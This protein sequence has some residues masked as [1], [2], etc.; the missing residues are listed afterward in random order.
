MNDAAFL[1]ILL[2]LIAL[3]G[4][5]PLVLRRFGIPGVIALLITGMLV[6]PTGI[7]CDLVGHISRWLSFLGT[8]GQEAETA[9]ATSESFNTIINS[10][11]SLGLM[12]LM[13]L[14]GMEA[15]FKLINSV[16]KPVVT[17][18]VLTFLL[19]AAAGY[20]VYWHF[21]PED[22]AGKLLYASLFASH[23]VG[24]VFPV[25]RELKLSKSRFG[26]A[27]LISTV[28]T[29]I[30]SIVLLAVSVQLHRQSLHVSH[31][32]GQSTLSIFDH[33]NTTSLLGNSFVLVFLLLV[34]V[35]L[36][37]SVYAVRFVGNV[38]KK[39]FAPTEDMLITI[40]LMV[41][42]VTVVIG[43]LFG[44]NLVVGAF[45]AG[46]GLSQVVKEKDMVLFKRVESIG[47]GFLIP[48]LFVS[49]GM[50]TDFTAFGSAGN[51]MII[52]L[53]VSGLVISKIFSG[54]IA[55]RISGFSNSQGVA[56]GLM[57]VPQ[58]S[59]TLAAAAIGKDMGLLSEEFFNA[60]IILSIVTTLPIPSLVK[61]VISKSKA[62]FTEADGVS[63]PSVVKSDELL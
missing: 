36:V 42:L 17:L 32:V 39:Y 27:V 29:D 33:V 56:A 15:D 25:M 13:A 23:S 37:V 28:I 8:P 21:R 30:A 40:V 48:F 24:I 35:Y 61:L 31:M 54:Y 26:A 9:L 44:I 41:I 19:P 2:A 60:I 57:T 6:G 46:L 16:K 51:W 55:M 43:E 50:K 20:L 62:S 47:Y 53:T 14:A 10:L 1:I 12:L 5:I 22:L 45:I 4:M 34:V 38:L 59:A 49:I 7:G 63:L 18:S 52:L 58:L 11:G 3:M